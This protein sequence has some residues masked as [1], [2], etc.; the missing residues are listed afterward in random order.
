M[1]GDEHGCHG[2][3]LVELTYAVSGSLRRDHH[4]VVRGGRHDAAEVDIEAVGEQQRSIRREV[5]L[6][7]SFV[8]AF[9]HVSGHEVSTDLATL[10]ALPNRPH[11]QP[12]F[13]A[14]VP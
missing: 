14:A 10:R 7:L 2:A 4:D 13:F 9:L 12:A 5:P 6:D 3:R 8:A 1:A 11:G